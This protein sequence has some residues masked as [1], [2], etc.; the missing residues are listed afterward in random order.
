MSN[1]NKKKL[2]R[3]TFFD[4]ISKTAIG[5]AVLNAIPFNLLGKA[6]VENPRSRK[7][8]KVNLHPKAVKRKN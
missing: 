3:R 7:L 6:G 8:K 5:F 1:T 2:N 4:W